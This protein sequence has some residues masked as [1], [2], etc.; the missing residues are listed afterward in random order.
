MLDAGLGD[1]DRIA[2]SHLEHGNIELAADGLKL[3]DGSRT[4]HVARDEQR[5]L[6]L[7]AHEPGELGAVG[8]LARALQADEHDDAR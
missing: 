7:L 2:L 4:V 5:T 6:A 3:L 1:R 8:G